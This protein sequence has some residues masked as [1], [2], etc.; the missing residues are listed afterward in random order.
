MGTDR[1]A[2]RCRRPRRTGEIA[3][4]L[5][6]RDPAPLGRGRARGGGPALSAARRNRRRGIGRTEP[7]ACVGD[8]SRQ[9]EVLT[10]KAMT[11][12]PA[13]IAERAASLLVL[14][15]AWEAAAWFA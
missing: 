13:A 9:R 12:F 2:Y 15:G 4:G 11:R 6:G 5:S 1:A 7:R 3:R 14:L 10:P 8:L